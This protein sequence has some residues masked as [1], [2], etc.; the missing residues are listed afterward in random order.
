MDEFLLSDVLK[1]C[2]KPALFRKFAERLWGISDFSEE[3]LL[4]TDEV[5]MLF[6]KVAEHLGA[7]HLTGSTVSLRALN[8]P[9][10]KR[11]DYAEVCRVGKALKPPITRQGDNDP[12]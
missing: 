11:A 9:L 3:W 4:T 10:S 5:R 12:D 1:C 6:I 7:A 2:T 8:A